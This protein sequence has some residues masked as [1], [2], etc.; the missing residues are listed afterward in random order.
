[1]FRWILPFGLEE[2]DV[3]GDEAEEV[4]RMAFSKEFQWHREAFN[5][6][7]VSSAGV[8]ILINLCL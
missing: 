7:I 2:V 1:M 3:T 5:R 4:V 8:D 6:L